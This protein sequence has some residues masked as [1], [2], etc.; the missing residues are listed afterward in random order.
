MAFSDVTLTWKGKKFT[1]IA[2]EIWPAVLIIEEQLC[3]PPYVCAAQLLVAP[4][5]VK[6]MELAKVYSDVLKHAGASVGVE[7]I[8]F[9]LQAEMVAETA[10][11][12]PLSGVIVMDLLR[13]CAPPIAAK[14]AELSEV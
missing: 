5:M 14:A 9:E 12:E 4:H 3:K 13:I 11:E 8:Y 1:I 6:K 7:E 10:N 2:K